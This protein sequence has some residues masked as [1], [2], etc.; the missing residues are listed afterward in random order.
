[1]NEED[2]LTYEREK[3]AENLLNRKY[4]ERISAYCG[5]IGRIRNK[6]SGLNDRSF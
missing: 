6:K 5:K 1:M 4:I 2:A 3:A